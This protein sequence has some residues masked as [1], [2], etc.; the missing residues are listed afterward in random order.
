MVE[1]ANRGTLFL[2]EI[3]DLNPAMQVKLLRLLQEGEYKT[4]GSNTIRKVDIRFVAATNR[5]LAEKIAKGEFR[6]DLFYR[7]NVINIH[8][9]PLRERREDIP[10][11]ANHFFAKY[12]AQHGKKVNRISPEAMSYLML[13]NWPGNVRELENVIERGLIMA[14]GDTLEISDLGMPACVPSPPECRAE[15]AE[16]DT[17]L[18]SLPFKEAKDILIERFQ[19]EY[20]SK[21]LSRNEG[22]VSQA[23]RESGMKRQYLHRLMRETSLESKTFKKHQQD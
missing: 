8:L 15:D 17:E 14:C 19:S 6:E 9:P 16:S 21:V 23:A 22:N 10:L 13:M 5:N 2:D 3:G 12:N 7:L 20:I 1:E 4:I 18:F 11:L